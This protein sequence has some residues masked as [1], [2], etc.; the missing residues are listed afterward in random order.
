MRMRWRLLSQSIN[1]EME[2][3]DGNTAGV[4]AGSITD[5]AEYFE[6]GKCIH[7]LRVCV[8]AT[9]TFSF[10]FFLNR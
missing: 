3:E 5:S 4:K 2:E 10:D 1:V 7:W 9:L 6:T 8:K